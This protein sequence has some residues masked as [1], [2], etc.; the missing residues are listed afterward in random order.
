[1]TGY[2][3]GYWFVMRN[4]SITLTIQFVTI[5]DVEKAANSTTTQGKEKKTGVYKVEHSPV[6]SQWVQIDNRDTTSSF[7]LREE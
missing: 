4:Q 7:P 1:M 3:K 2:K 6:I 5:D